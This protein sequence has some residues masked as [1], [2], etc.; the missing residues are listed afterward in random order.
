MWLGCV[1][2]KSVFLQQAQGQTVMVGDASADVMVGDASAAG[3][4]SDLLHCQR[5]GDAV[6]LAMQRATAIHVGVTP[7]CRGDIQ[8]AAEPTFRRRS[9]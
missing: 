4:T 5:F 3:V 8:L 7:V 9:G 6:V 2:W 1:C